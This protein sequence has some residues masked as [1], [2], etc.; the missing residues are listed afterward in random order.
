MGGSKGGSVGSYSSGSGEAVGNVLEKYG[1]NET[2]GKISKVSFRLRVHRTYRR[3]SVSSYPIL[4]VFC[5]F[6]RR[7]VWTPTVLCSFLYTTEVLSGPV[8]CTAAQQ[9]LKT[10]LLSDVGRRMS[11]WQ[12]EVQLPIGLYD[13]MP[14]HTQ[15]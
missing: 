4:R 12:L 14:Y 11:S 2:E 3:P 15:I 5:V 7:P 1:A 10:Y 8:R 6:L 9:Y 13:T